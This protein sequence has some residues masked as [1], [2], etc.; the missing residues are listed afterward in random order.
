MIITLLSLALLAADT[1]DP[2]A[3]QQ[4]GR[5]I[6]ARLVTNRHAP[7]DT[8]SAT[9][10]VVPARGMRAL[11]VGSYHGELHF[12]STAATVVRVEKPTGGVRVENATRKGRVNF[13]GAAPTGFP[14]RALVTV[15]LQLRSASARPALLLR[16]KELN[17][18][19]GQKLLQ[20]LVVEG[21]PR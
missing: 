5:A 19:G 7:G 10:C 14:G 8:M 9:V 13:A 11:E 12:D 15:V 2:C 20:E 18:T 16:I 1:T 3:G 6:T 4:P 21:A 17:T